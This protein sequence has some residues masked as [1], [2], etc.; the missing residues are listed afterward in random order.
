MLS[1]ARVKR[2]MVVRVMCIAWVMERARR[3][4]VQ[5]GVAEGQANGTS[6]SCNFDGALL[7]LL[8]ERNCSRVI[9]ITN[10]GN[11]AATDLAD[12]L[13]RRKSPTFE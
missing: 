1:L 9:M 2:R 13:S 5:G 3:W 6:H 7:S 12:E 11:S 8:A 10:A 4:H